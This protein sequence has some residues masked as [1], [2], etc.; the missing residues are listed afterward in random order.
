MKEI[1]LKPETV[2]VF[3]G[4]PARFV[5]RSCLEPQDEILEWNEKSSREGRMCIRCECFDLAMLREYFVEHNG[6]RAVYRIEHIVTSYKAMVNPLEWLKVRFDVLLEQTAVLFAK[7]Q[8]LEKELQQQKLSK[9]AVLA[10]SDTLSEMWWTTSSLDAKRK[11][12]RVREMA[13]EIRALEVDSPETVTPS[14]ENSQVKM[15][16]PC[17]KCGRRP[18]SRCGRTYTAPDE[19]GFI[20][21]CPNLCQDDAIGD[22]QDQADLNWNTSNPLPA[23]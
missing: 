5:C 13:K 3:V 7:Q 14:V 18:D 19:S 8:R 10:I 17:C 15:L 9:K 20:R 11:I 12:E 2:G 1:K 4:N 22:T 16:N 6:C 21:G 23:K